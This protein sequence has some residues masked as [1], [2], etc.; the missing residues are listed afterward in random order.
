M[1]RAKAFFLSSA[2]I[3]WIV[4]VA[5]QVVLSIFLTLIAQ[6][7]LIGAIGIVAVALV[8]VG[9]VPQADRAN[10]EKSGD[11]YSLYLRRVPGMNIVVGLIRLLRRGSNT[12]KEVRGD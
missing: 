9:I 7:W 6:H 3:L 8:C 12:G 4:F 10:I 2:W 5:A 1:E 11:A